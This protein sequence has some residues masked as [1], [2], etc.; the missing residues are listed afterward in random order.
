VLVAPAVTFHVFSTEQ[1][2]INFGSLRHSRR[3]RSLRDLRREQTNGEPAALELDR[4]TKDDALR[5]L[6]V[7]SGPASNNN[8]SEGNG[9]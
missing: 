7:G 6:L 2:V 4:P 1:S 8:H 5:R 9:E 3:S